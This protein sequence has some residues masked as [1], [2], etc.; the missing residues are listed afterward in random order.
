MATSAAAGTRMDARIG[1]AIDDRL[2]L[3]TAAGERRRKRGEL[4][5]SA[6]YDARAKRLQIELSS[7]V[8]VSIPV[9]KLE[10][11]AGVPSSVIKTVRVDGG[12]YGLRWS[13]LDLDLAVPDLIAGCF[14]SRAWMSALARQGGKATTTA[15]RRAARETGKKGGR[16]RRTPS[17]VGVRAR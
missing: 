4:A 6:R 2:A 14:G 15:K 8:A 7:G 9:A 13:L 3:A 1:H 16:P 5:V 10:G 11:L 12:G 17:E